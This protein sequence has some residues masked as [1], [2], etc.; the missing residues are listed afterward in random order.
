MKSE[1]T[2]A[3]TESV[4]VRWVRLAF[5]LAVMAAAWFALDA[6]MDF[7]IARGGGQ[8]LFGLG[9]LILVPFAAGAVLGVVIQRF[10]SST[11]GVRIGLV[12][13]GIF[14]IL[15]LLTGPG[16]ICV[17]IAAPLWFPSLVLGGWASDWIVKRSLPAQAVVTTLVLALSCGVWAFDEAG[18][19][20]TQQYTVEREVTVTAST[21][22]VWP[23]LLR[24]E[25]LALREGRRTFS[26]DVLGVPRPVEAIVLGEGLGAV[27][28]GRWSGGVWFEEYIVGWVGERQLDWAFV[29]PEGSTFASID[30]HIDPRGPNVVIER[31]G[32]RLDALPDGST[33]LRLY[34]TYTLSTA[35]NGYAEQWAQRILG[36]VQS[37]ILEIAKVRAEAGS[38]AQG[39]VL[40]GEIGANE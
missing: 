10:W 32:Y 28:T 12:A 4:Q 16:V 13:S 21:E 37:N 36:D 17:V 1:Q 33:R 27:R 6:V 23:H 9:F 24:L 15:S 3:P 7:S 26:H 20:P 30:Q 2:H 34:T 39:V 38:N 8:G 29:F 11:S 40:A 5:T 31:G 19:Y 22:E 25:S 14:L 18:R 35:V